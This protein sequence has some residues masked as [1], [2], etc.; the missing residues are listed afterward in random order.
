VAA[1][2]ASSA[3]LDE[4]AKAGAVKIVEVDL[5][6]PLG[7]AGLHRQHQRRRHQNRRRPHPHLVARADREEN[8]WLC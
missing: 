3:E 7:P 1:A 4:L 5:T 2:R 8:S 6:E